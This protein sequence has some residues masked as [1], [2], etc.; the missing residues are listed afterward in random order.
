MCYFDIEIDK[1]NP[2]SNPL[3]LKGIEGMLYKG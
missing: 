3:E 2:I 1:L